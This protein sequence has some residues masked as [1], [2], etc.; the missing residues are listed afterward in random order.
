MIPDKKRHYD[1]YLIY[2]SQDR[3]QVILSV[4]VLTWPI[5]FRLGSY[6]AVLGGVAVCGCT[7]YL[8]RITSI[9]RR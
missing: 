5:L 9:L 8:K 2:M 4:P 3:E 7:T 6:K 1:C